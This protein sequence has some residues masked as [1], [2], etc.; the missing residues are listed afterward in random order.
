MKKFIIPL[1][2][3]FSSLISA[4]LFSQNTITFTIGTIQAIPGQL[5]SIPI[6]I[7]GA[8]GT[9]AIGVGQFYI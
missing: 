7:S 1:L 3:I 9:N 6:S 2:I 8:N 4:N 5:V